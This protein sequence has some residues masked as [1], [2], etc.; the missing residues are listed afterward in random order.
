MSRVNPGFSP[1]HI[2]TMRVSPN[3]SLC[4]RRESCISLY[5][6][7]LG[8]ARGLPEVSDVAAANT[9]PLDGRIPAIPVDVEDH[10]KSADF[11]APMFWAGAVTP[12]YFQVL[13]I[14]LLEGRLFTGADGT[15]SSGVVILTVST[16]RRFWPGRS[17]IGKHVKAASE[18]QWRSVIGVVSDVHQ[19]DLA[20]RSPDSIG[21]AMYM[22]Y[23][24]SVQGDLQIPAAMNLLVKTAAPGSRLAGEIRRIARELNPNVPAGEVAALQEIVSVS[25][26]DFRSTIWVFLGFAAAAMG[27]AAVGIYGLVSHSVAQR[28]YEIG[29]RVAIGATRKEI[30]GLVL[31]Q[32][33]RLTLTG[34]TAGAAASLVL[35]RFLAGLL[36]GVAATDAVTFT[37]GCGL[38]LGIAAIASYAPAWRAA[39]LDPIR[40]LRAE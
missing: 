12:D 35:T 19:F 8:E 30:L 24:Q 2:L 22:P 10:P 6:R 7:L 39:N 36:F 32:S 5:D 40:S 26:S 11:P 25:T 14:P 34:I 38:L 31:A 18:A 28:T 15:K 3:Q 23:P 17:A 29:V 13:H 4:S 16:A 1:E 9:V 20:G 21:G 27:L 37:A 33:L